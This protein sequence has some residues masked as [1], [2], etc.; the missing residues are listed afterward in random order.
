MEGPPP[1]C[2]GLPGTLR[3]D[4]R[5]CEGEAA[6]PGCQASRRAPRNGAARRSAAAAAICRRGAAAPVGEH[7][8][9]WAGAFGLVRVPFCPC[10]RRH[11]PGRLRVHVR[12]RP[13]ASDAAEPGRHAPQAAGSG[14]LTPRSRLT[15]RWFGC[16]LARAGARRGAAGDLWAARCAGGPGRTGC[17]AWGAAVGALPSVKRLL[18]EAVQSEGFDADYTRVVRVLESRAGIE[19]HDGGGTDGAHGDYTAP[20]FVSGNRAAK[21]QKAK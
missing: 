18:E 21:K 15:L 7:R 2:K 6:P 10:C 20:P 11:A 13:A 12:R 3:G 5:R 19:L 1:S 14:L 17:R 16:W 8:R 9:G 4:W